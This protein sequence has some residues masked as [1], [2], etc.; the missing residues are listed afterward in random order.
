[1]IPQAR[2]RERISELEQMVRSL[3]EECAE[4]KRKY[5]ESQNESLKA[6]TMNELL[7]EKCDEA[8]EMVAEYKKETAEYK[9]QVA[10][11]AAH[12][13]TC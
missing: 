2:E 9:N 3:E 5:D 8:E 4:W 13:V 6:T 1:M 7:K 10:Q 12:L 11:V